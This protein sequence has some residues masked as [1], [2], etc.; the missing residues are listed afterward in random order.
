[1]TGDY[2]GCPTE[3]M[4]RMHII[5]QTFGR[6]QGNWVRVWFEKAPS[7]DPSPVEKKRGRVE[8]SKFLMLSDLDPDLIF[9]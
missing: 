9:R 5:A 6:S 1:M 7:L 4:F 2:K 8:L 3:F